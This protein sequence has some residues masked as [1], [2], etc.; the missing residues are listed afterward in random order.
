[1][2]TPSSSAA[3]R[4]LLPKVVLRTLAHGERTLLGEFRIAKGGVIP[5]HSHPH[6]Q[7]GYLVS[8]LLRFTIDGK[9]S[10]AKPGDA[11]CIAGGVEHGAVALEDTVVIEM[12]SPVR[13]EYLPPAS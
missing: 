10:D 9:S 4:T 11:W 13:E 5:P 2:F 6:E 3:S 7:T 12:F 8:G 1:M